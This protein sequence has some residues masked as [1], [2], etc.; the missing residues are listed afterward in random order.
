MQR[1]DEVLIALRRIIRATDLHS[2]QLNKSAGL[3][4]PQLMVLQTLQNNEEMTIGAVAQRVSLSQATVTT[5]ID[6]LENRELVQRVRDQQDRRKV[7]LHLTDSARALLIKAPT[8]LQDNFVRQFQNLQD[9]EQGMIVSA[10]ER[11]AFMMDAQH[12][13]AAPMLDLGVLDSQT[14]DN[15]DAEISSSNPVTDLP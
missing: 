11:I 15:H 6:R 12:L 9:W 7:H 14:P 1:H 8:P 3:T 2:R 10:L 13:D 5:I 4:T